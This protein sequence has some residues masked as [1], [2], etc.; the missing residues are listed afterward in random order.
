MLSPCRMRGLCSLTRA[1]HSYSSDEKSSSSSLAICSDVPVGG[2]RIGT[3]ASM[4][5][6]MDRLDVQLVGERVANGSGSGTA[7]LN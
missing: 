1:S 7:N 6:V 5:C 3:R 2:V 4:S